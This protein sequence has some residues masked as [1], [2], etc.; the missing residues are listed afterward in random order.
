MAARPV[1]PARG[2][3]PRDA[4]RMAYLQTNR[5][6]QALERGEAEEAQARFERAIERA[7]GL[8]ARCADGDIDERGASAA[9]SRFWGGP[10]CCRAVTRRRAARAL[11]LPE[12]APERLDARMEAARSAGGLR[13]PGRGDEQRSKSRAGFSGPASMAT[14]R[15]P[16][17]EWR[18]MVATGRTRRWQAIR[19]CSPC[20]SGRTSRTCCRAERHRLGALIGVRVGNANEGLRSPS[21]CGFVSR[22]L[23]RPCVSEADETQERLDRRRA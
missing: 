20:R 7:A 18:S 3:Q 14:E 6:K 4:V 22:S 19:S 10:C 9:D 21:I 12:T 17:F 16:S 13:A 23:R 15:S 2:C 1:E 5:G 11:E 8:P